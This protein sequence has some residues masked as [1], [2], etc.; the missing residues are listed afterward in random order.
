MCFFS[1]PSSPAPWHVFLS[2]RAQLLHLQ[3]L[4]FAADRKHTSSR[5]RW[6]NMQIFWGYPFYSACEDRCLFEKLEYCLPKEQ[7]LYFYCGLGLHNMFNENLCLP[8]FIKCWCVSV[9]A[10]ARSKKKLP[11]DV[12]DGRLCICYLWMIGSLFKPAG[13]N[14]TKHYHSNP[15]RR[16]F[17]LLVTWDLIS[18]TK[19]FFHLAGNEQ[20][21]F[22]VWT[23]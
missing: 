3:T 12:R 19:M 4:L 21:C 18:G 8:F 16:G 9:C 1:F 22:C 20:N 7:I 2:R 14:T 10:F 13:G 11:A 15:K 6:S 23:V 5:L 17:V